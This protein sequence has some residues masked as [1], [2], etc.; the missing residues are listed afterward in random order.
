MVKEFIAAE[1][2][3]IYVRVLQEGSVREGDKLVLIE[4]NELSLSVRDVYRLLYATDK[5]PKLLE[6]AFSDP[7][8]ADSCKQDLVN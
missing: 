5:H 4:R 7:A 8:L 1:F 6:R 3:G 2:S